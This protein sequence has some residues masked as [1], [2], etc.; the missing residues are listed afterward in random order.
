M[1]FETLLNNYKLGPVQKWH[2]QK[3]PPP[4]FV[5]KKLIL[6]YQF[7]ISCNEIAIPIWTDLKTKKII[8]KMKF[9]QITVI[10]ALPSEYLHLIPLR[11]VCR[12]YYN[13]AGDVNYLNLFCNKNLETERNWLANN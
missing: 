13:S 8:L 2:S 6:M 9:P 7:Q 3:H 5:S 11:A 12:L 1:W 4:L 10:S